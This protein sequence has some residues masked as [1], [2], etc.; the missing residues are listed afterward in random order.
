MTLSFILI[1]ILTGTV[2][3][4]LNFISGRKHLLGTLL[5]LEGVIMMLFGLTAC[6]RRLVQFNF[7]LLV[8]ITFVACE[9]ALALSLLVVA[10]RW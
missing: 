8:F 3:F 9:G 1:T 2:L 4:I 7:F 10:V 6:L 5:R